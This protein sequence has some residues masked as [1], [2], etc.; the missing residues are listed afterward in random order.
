LDPVIKSHLLYQLSYEGT[1]V[2]GVPEEYTV[3]PKKDL[4]PLSECRIVA[5]YGSLARATFLGKS[6]GDW[7]H[8][9]FFSKALL[10]EPL[11]FEDTLGNLRPYGKRFCRNKASCMFR[12]RLE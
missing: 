9:E 4:N 2:L 5:S 11:A 8:I 10:T 12:I 7:P 3:H 1:F 6:T